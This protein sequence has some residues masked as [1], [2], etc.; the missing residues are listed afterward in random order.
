[1]GL[2]AV[3]NIRLRF[4]TADT[5]RHGNVRY[6]VRLPGKAKTRLGGLPGSAEFMAA[7]YAA[8]AGVQDEPR[9]H[10]P[11][12]PGSFSALCLAYYATPE[13]RGLDVSTKAWHRRA[14][15][16][17]CREH[18]DKPVARLTSR[19]VRKLRDEK[20]ETPGAANTLLKALRALFAWAVEAE[21]LKHNPTTGV[22]AISYATKGFHSWSLEEVAQFE[23][24]HP[25]GTR[26]RLAMALLL[27]TAC[28][29]EDAV[30]FG[31]QHMR[32]GRLRYTQAK[33]EHRKPVAMD[34]PVHPDLAAAVEATPS[35]NL[36]F[37]V[38]EYGKPF[39]VAGF[40]NRF[41]E[42]CDQAGLPHCSAHGLRKATAARLAERGATS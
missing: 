17:I 38:T 36:T 21:E 7:Y 32:A 15:D 9:R 42:W 11:A 37:L 31:R 14:L 25:I 12:L 5:D 20:A 27:Y 29:R 10:R 41:R 2:S 30:R 34:I 26:P 18:G 35:K 23:A 6:Y 13:F 24:R 40:G 33:N 1:M 4:V 28:R 16:G 22:K 39:S 8:L 3:V 19:N